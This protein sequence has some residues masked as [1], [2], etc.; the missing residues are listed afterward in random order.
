MKSEKRLQEGYREMASDPEQSDTAKGWFRRL[1][2]LNTSPFPP[3]CQPGAPKR[4]V[5]K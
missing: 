3:R 4:D 1:D 2:E 5:F